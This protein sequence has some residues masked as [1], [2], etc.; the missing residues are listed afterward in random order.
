VSRRGAPESKPAP[1]RRIAAILMA[2]VAGYSRLVGDDEEGTLVRLRVLRRELIYRESDAHRGRVVRV[3]GDGF[4][5]EFSSA[6]DAV[7]CAVAVQRCMAAAAQEPAERR[8]Q[9]RIGIDVGD[10]LA[11]GEDILGD[12]VNIAA[13]LEGIAE[14]GGI[15]LSAAACEQVRGKLDIAVADIGEPKLKNIARPVRVYR[16]LL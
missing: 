3:M 4:L 16:V 13:R 2:D 5:I 11:D 1:A 10:V 6:V 15:C 7:R 8:L 12:S 9:F 14:P